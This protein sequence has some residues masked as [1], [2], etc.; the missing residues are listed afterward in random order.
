M[1]TQTA[2]TF[3][4]PVQR[5]VEPHVPIDRQPFTPRFSNNYRDQQFARRAF[6]RTPAL[7]ESRLYGS[8]RRALRRLLEQSTFPFETDFSPQSERPH[9]DLTL[10]DIE[11]GGPSPQEFF[12]RH[13]QRVEL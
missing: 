10:T 12:F 9:P 6:P 8:G 4:R 5:R 13:D 11:E 1:T 3:L 7:A 2:G